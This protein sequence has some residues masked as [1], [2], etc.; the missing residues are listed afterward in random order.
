MKMA[1][2]SPGG[3]WLAPPPFLLPTPLLWEQEGGVP[4]FLQETME[5]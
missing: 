1:V 5:A 4:A 2:V 3:S